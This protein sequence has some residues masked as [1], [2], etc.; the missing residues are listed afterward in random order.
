[1]IFREVAKLV[2][3]TG[4]NIGSKTLFAEQGKL[5]P[6]VCQ[7]SNCFTPLLNKGE[8]HCKDS[9]Q[10]L[11]AKQGKLGSCSACLIAVFC[12]IHLQLA[13]GQVVM[14][15]AGPDSFIREAVELV[16]ALCCSWEGGREGDSGVK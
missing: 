5:P 6:K 12:C 7:H 14:L 15:H 8:L 1:M 3:A 9:A 13:M 10:K 2:R 16:G 11:L 4:C